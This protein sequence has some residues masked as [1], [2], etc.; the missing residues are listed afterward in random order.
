MPI[1]VG[2][3]AAASTTT[4]AAPGAD[5]ISRATAQVFNDFGL[6]H[7]GLVRELADAHWAF[8]ATLATTTHAFS[9]AESAIAGTLRFGMP[10]GTT[11]A[12]AAAARQAAT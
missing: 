5:L 10:G 2:S 1:D 6:Q 8:G 4:I 11:G 3:A 7:Q 12:M 9:G